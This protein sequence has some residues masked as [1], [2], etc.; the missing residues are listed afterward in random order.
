M[1]VLYIDLKSAYNTVDRK[2]L[3]E[4]IRLRNILE[5]AELS[6]LEALY[7]SIY[8]KSSQPTEK[9][10]LLNGLPQGSIL[11][12]LLFNIYM[13]EVIQDA[14]STFSKYLFKKIYADD[15]VVITKS[16]HLNE[17]MT[18]IRS[19]FTRYSLIFNQKKSQIQLIRDKRQE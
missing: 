4:V 19:A 6:F 7:N 2:K 11:S 16:K 5:P 10:F 15:M 8:Y 9:H 18:A 3:F 1:S 17:F 14:L 12:P 13:D